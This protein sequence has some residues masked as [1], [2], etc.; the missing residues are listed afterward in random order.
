[1]PGLGDALRTINV[2]FKAVD[3]R[4]SVVKRHAK[5]EFDASVGRLGHTPERSTMLRRARVG[6][7]ACDKHALFR[8][9]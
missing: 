4:G 3:G 1:M 9:A 6:V 2:V 8:M 5:H 7:L